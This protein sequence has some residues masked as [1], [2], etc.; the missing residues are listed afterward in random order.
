MEKEVEKA[1]T[2]ASKKMQKAFKNVRE[3]VKEKGF[4][5]QV[6]CTG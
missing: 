2:T 5:R 3:N 4:E 6:V 1:F